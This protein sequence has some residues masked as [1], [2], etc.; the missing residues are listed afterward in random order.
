MVSDWHLAKICILLIACAPTVHS[1]EQQLS[2]SKTLTSSSAELAKKTNEIAAS[3]AGVFSGTKA[4]Q[5]AASQKKFEADYEKQY[6]ISKSMDDVSQLAN[7]ANKAMADANAKEAQ[8][9]GEAA[10]A[11]IEAQSSVEK[12]KVDMKLANTK[13]LAETSQQLA[14]E[15]MSLSLKIG[16]AQK[17]VADNSGAVASI[18]VKAAKDV[19]DT[20]NYGSTNMRGLIAKKKAAAE[21]DAS[22]AMTNA[23]TEETALHAGSTEALAKDLAAAQKDQAAAAAMLATMQKWLEE[24]KK[25]AS[26]LLQ[27]SFNDLKFSK[28]FPSEVIKFGATLDSR[29]DT[30]LMD[31]RGSKEMAPRIEEP[32][33]M[34]GRPYMVEGVGVVAETSSSKASPMSLLDI[35]RDLLEDKLCEI[36]NS[37]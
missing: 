6:A 13:A 2:I 37:C 18:N 14:A 22:A 15:K 9:K 5:E 24:G 7:K 29:G 4:K 28:H 12:V 31:A 19:A 1:Y 3:V 20:Y 33:I 8:L 17:T 16:N 30:P 36:S 10:Q 11:A 23:M 25:D 35:S 26:T 27:K 21:A 34:R 32:R